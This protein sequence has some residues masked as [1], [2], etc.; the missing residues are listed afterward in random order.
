MNALVWEA[1]REMALRQE[2]E[3]IPAPG[4]VLIKVA[5]VGI[6]GSEIGG[7]LG[8]NALRKPPL[9]MGHEFSGTVAGVGEGVSRVNVGQNVTCNPLLYCGECRYCRSGLRQLCPKRSLIGAHRPGAFANFVTVPEETVVVLPD[10]VGLRAG[11]MVEPIAV[12][13][14]LGRLA[15]SL[16]GET[17]L[18]IGAG[19]IGL[20]A[21]QALFAQGAATV[22]VSD[23]DAERA[24]MASELGG[25]L[26]D[27]ATQS[28]VEVVRAATG[29]L[30]A[31]VSVDAVGSGRTRTDAVAATRAAGK[32]LLS[33]L[34]E[35][36]SAFPGS[37]VIRREIEVKG[38]FS[39]TPDDF[40]TAVEAA[41][42]K[43]LR[44]DPW[45]VEAPLSEGGAWFARLA[46][47][48]GNVSKVLLVP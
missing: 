8:H 47:R 18:V 29:G 11:A 20:L 41:R 34:H 7:Y 19:P 16:E 14:R 3:P 6:C 36:A 38:V 25:T 40:A 45:T 42:D 21:V 46:D 33:G 13:V 28:V 32:V 48:P 17:A 35:E 15:G 23:M 1:P 10:G 31:A 30:G 24:K 37:D 39:Y 22:F 5:Y 44:L 2:P 27:P 9:V 43:T 26:I 4:E 12:G